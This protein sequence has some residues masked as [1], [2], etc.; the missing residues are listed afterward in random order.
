VRFA[1]YLLVPAYERVAQELANALVA[2]P[3]DVIMQANKTFVK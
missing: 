1:Q 2:H 3:V